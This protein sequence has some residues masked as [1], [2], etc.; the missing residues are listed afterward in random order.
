M[1][2][3]P[4][5]DA[6]ESEIELMRFPSMGASLLLLVTIGLLLPASVKV[7][8]PASEYPSG[9]LSMLPVVGPFGVFSAS[10]A[11]IAP[12]A[13]PAPAKPHPVTS[14]SFCLASA[15]ATFASPILGA[16]FS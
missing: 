8:P 14:C 4:N 12:P 15:S 11:N 9:F 16:L 10:F 3:D 7:E 13:A 2:L 5:I 6:N 1:V